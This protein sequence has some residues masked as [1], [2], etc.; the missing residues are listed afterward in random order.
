M[1]KELAV[2]HS[3]SELERMADAIVQSK[4]FGISTKPQAVAL[5]VVAQAEGKHPG[6]VAS[7]Y[8]II[9]G[10]ASLKADSML[11]RFQQAGG[12]V[13]WHDHTDEK[14]SATFSH[15]AGSSLKIEWDMARAKSAGLGGKDNWKKYPRQMLRA[16]VISEGVR[17]VYPAVLQGMYTPEEV[18]DFGATPNIT[19]EEVTAPEDV[20]EVV[21][22]RVEEI[23][24]E[25]VP[26][27]VEPEWIAAMEEH[28]APHEKKVNNFLRKK[29]QIGEG[30]TWRQVGNKAYRDRML[31]NTDKFLHNVL[32]G[33][34]K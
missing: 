33:A 19:K 11:A 13:E 8:H 3:V 7:E 32:G 29:E 15:P 16:R 26:D 30:Q 17:A 31:A 6:S 12:K 28:L 14:V 20:I 5:M 21:A 18:G 22:Q 4:L 24:V 2:N 1:S 10:R 9:Q 34:A 27:E 23:E 25:I